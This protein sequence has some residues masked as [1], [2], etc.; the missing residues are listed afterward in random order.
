ML[1]AQPERG[2]LVT[3]A[4]PRADH[5]RGFT[6]IELMVV[7]TILA[8]LL[9]IAAPAVSNAIQNA[10]TSALVHRLPQDVAWVRSK[11]S[12]SPVPY[13]IV[14]GPGCQ[15]LVQQGSYDATGALTWSATATTE[16]TAHS[17]STAAT[18]YPSATCTLSGAGTQQAIQFNRQGQ[19][20]N[21][22]APTVTIASGN[23]QVWVLQVLLSGLVL[24]NAGTSS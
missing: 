19:I 1:G 18:D 14:I 24:L 20:S 22:V 3:S 10:R 7:I 17:L 12:S 6:L 9:L 13:Q 2:L 16:T 8:M 21:S 4:E 15:W 5:S 23:G 11:A